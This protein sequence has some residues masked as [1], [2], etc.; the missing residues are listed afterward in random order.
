MREY[1]TST[2]IIWF[3]Y[4][5]DAQT[6]D[7]EFTSG[8]TYRYFDVNPGTADDLRMAAS[9]GAYVNDTIKPFHRFERL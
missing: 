9:K 8:G 4:D 3:D 1:V 5:S 6:L 2:S 7:V